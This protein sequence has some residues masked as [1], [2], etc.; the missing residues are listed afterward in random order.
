M[1]TPARTSPVTLQDVAAA[2]GVSLATASRS[3]N[4]SSRK[5]NEEYRERVAAAATLLGYTPNLSAQAV[6]KGATSTVAL[7]VSDI[8]DPYFSSI[9]A[10]LMRAAEQA[11]LIVTMAVTDRDAE[12]ELEL[13]RT[14]RGQRPR[15]LILTG[16][17][18]VGSELEEALVKELRA[19]EETGGRVVIVSQAGL[20][21][22]TVVTNN[23]SGAKQLA[24]TL[25]DQG[26][27][28]FAAITGAP[29]LMTS[30]DRLRGFAD[31]L[32]ER[33]LSIPSARIVEAGFTRDGGSAGAD[34]LLDRGT[35]DIELVFAVNDVMAIG[36]MSRF[37]EAGLSIPTDLAM[38][39]FDDIA[40]ARDVSPALTTVRLPLEAIGRA[41]L[42][43]ALTPR[44]GERRNTLA[45]DGEV[46]LRGSTPPR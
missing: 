14:L 34:M 42:E 2:A 1:T 13:V 38:A 15:V 41:A 12:R 26:Y 20:P 46:I 28:S 5:V 3:L 4:G 19:F 6:A 23:Y 11:R 33:G 22:D 21:F 45:V 30:R 29:D 44:D 17:R 40:T 18:F 8:A 39:G 10:G 37:R 31:G 35:A 7:M 16:S 9:A 25:V 36:A 24:L 27:R 32:A 43:Q